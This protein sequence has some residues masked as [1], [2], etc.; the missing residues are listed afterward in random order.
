MVQA[1]SNLK[2]PRVRLPKLKIH[3]GRKW[4]RF[5][6]TEGIALTV[7]IPAAALAL[8]HYFADPVMNFV[9]NILTIAAAAA[10][11]VVPIVF[12]AVGPTLPRVER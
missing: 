11:G 3:I 6:L 10:A 7:L 2:A 4:T 12:F 9:L 5:L 8:S 1:L